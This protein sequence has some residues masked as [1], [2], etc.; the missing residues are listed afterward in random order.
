[1]VIFKCYIA[2]IQ[3]RMFVPSKYLTAWEL[4]SVQVFS[5][6]MFLL[7]FPYSF[8]TCIL[9]FHLFLSLPPIINVSSTLHC[10][11]KFRQANMSHWLLIFFPMNHKYKCHVE[12]FW[13]ANM[14][15]T[16]KQSI[17]TILYV[18]RFQFLLSEDSEVNLYGKCTI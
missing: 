10:Y 11:S 15:P 9:V 2:L 1:M 18:N 14:K 13:K 4:S 6:W 8:E 7:K 3:F 17:S 5:Q 12:I 16:L